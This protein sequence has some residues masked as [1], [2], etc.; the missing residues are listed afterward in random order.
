MEVK[1]KL[2]MVSAPTM[3]ANLPVSKLKIKYRP[4][5]IKEQKA[6]LLAQE[7]KDP[8][9]VFETIKSVILSC[10]DGTLDFAKVPMADLAYFF[11]QLRIA[12][13]GPQ[14]R[15][16]IKCSAC[17]A[18][19]IINMS[20]EDVKVD[21]SKIITEVKIT[22]NVGIKFRIPTV[23]DSVD[24]DGDDFRSIR[25]LY[26]LIDCIYDEET[27]Y[28]K[29][30]Y[31]EEEF[32]DWIES[33]NDTQALEIAKFV[34]SIPDLSHTFEFDCSECNHHQSRTV[35]GLH[36]FFRFGSDS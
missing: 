30:D 24:T 29:E 27:V 22:E 31:T 19:N 36:N 34:E 15:F 33:L 12:S 10:T 35:E 16:G 2:P 13:V 28:Q 18:D 17:Q 14:V 6:L 8:E 26:T 9:V 32:T 4:F 5:V 11:L 7:S 20:L 3:V 21:T 23:A 1:K 25:L